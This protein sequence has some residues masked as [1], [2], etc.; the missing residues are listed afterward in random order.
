M[1]VEFR[2]S[3]AKA[4]K[5]VLDKSLLKKVKE[6]IEKIEKAENLQEI[7]NRKKLIRRRQSFSTENR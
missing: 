5:S 7:T 4:L 2:R 6:T 1:N 3:F